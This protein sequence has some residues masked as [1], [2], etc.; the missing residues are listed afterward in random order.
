M[1]NEKKL[2]TEEKMTV[3]KTLNNNMVLAR[4]SDGND[5][6]CQ[7]KGIG[8]RKKSGDSIVWSQV[9]RSYIP[10]NEQDRRYFQQLFSEIPDEYWEIAEKVVEYGRDQYQIKVSDRVILPLCDHMAGSVERYKKGTTLSNPMLW[11]IKRV[12]SDEFQI[13]KYA[14]KI[15][16]ERFNVEMKEDEAAFLAYHFVNAELG[17]LPNISPD[18]IATLIASVLDIVQES[19]QVK[20][21]D[22]D[23]NYQRFVTHLK[24]FASRIVQ[25]AGYQNEADDELYDELSE[26]YRPVRKCVDRIAD[27]I[28]INY[29]YDLSM[30]ERLYLLIHIQRVTKKYL[31]KKKSGAYSVKTSSDANTQNEG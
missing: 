14:L 19:F 28:L 31:K 24:F 27:Y 4:D 20:L 7:G 26:R 29:H 17:S 15:L 10:E 30:D 8:F 18:S 12:Y 3:I 5:R 6:I 25:R 16:Q 1:I 21:N 2:V 11:D 9:E 22:E 23:W 13:G